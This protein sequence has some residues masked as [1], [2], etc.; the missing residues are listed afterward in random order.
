MLA[1]SWKLSVTEVGFIATVGEK[2]KLESRNAPI[3]GVDP[4]VVD[5]MLPASAWMPIL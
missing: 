5:T 1:L 3:V 4:N 2:V